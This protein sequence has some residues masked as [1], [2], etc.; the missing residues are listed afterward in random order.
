MR[1][2]ITATRR[3]PVSF[4]ELK[5]QDLIATS[6]D[7][8]VRTGEISNAYLFSGPQG[9]GKTTAARLLAAALQGTSSEQGTPSGK[10][11]QA[12]VTYAPWVNGGVAVDVIEIDGASHSGVHDV[13]AIRDQVLYP[14]IEYPYK[15]YIID[16]VHM[17]S[18]SAF[19][20]LLKTIEEPPS[21]IVFIFATTELQRMPVTI[22]SRCQQFHFQTIESPVIV[23]SL[24]EAGKEDSLTIE[25]MAAELMA[26]EAHGSLRDAYML[27][28]QIKTIAPKGK[29]SEKLALEHLGYHG[30]PT[31][32]KLVL[33]I[34]NAEEKE[35]QNC[36]KTLFANGNSVQT[37]LSFLMRMFRTAYCY[38]LDI[39]EDTL[40]FFGLTPES[41]QRY[42][43]MQC[44][45][46]VFRCIEVLR[47][48]QRSDF[49][50]VEAELLISD[51]CRLSSYRSLTELVA[52]LQT[53]A[54]GDAV[55]N[56]SSN[57]F[58]IPSKG[59]DYEERTT[60][61]I[62]IS[63]D[64]S[65][66]T[67]NNVSWKSQQKQEMT[68]L[69]D[70]A[71][72]DKAL[73]NYSVAKTDVQEEKKTR[74]AKTSSKLEAERSGDSKQNPLQWFKEVIA[75]SQDKK[76]LID[77]LSMIKRAW[78]EGKI[79]H[80]EV[81][82]QGVNHVISEN[83]QHTLGVLRSFDSIENIICHIKLRK[84][85]HNPTLSEMQP[86]LQGKISSNHE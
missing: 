65:E 24:Q 51:M 82:D 70:T 48:V 25:P 55:V 67:E 79:M 58:S 81:P 45:H 43:T 39:E 26:R 62:N 49:A 29:I 83:K 6:L 78:I 4:E 5:G 80:I 75:H 3:R 19:N 14:P 71:S 66:S 11:K 86:I 61:G 56:A 33:H 28:D 47:D 60:E 72:K 21:Y 46:G 85:G 32:R 22:R 2:H 69:E 18:N 54:S 31:F 44:E 53:L 17:L 12:S 34:L 7:K 20:A 42:S 76:Y 63:V 40:S 52:D 36:L 74:K 30:M 64:I 68:G 10:K 41:I 77:S 73:D 15:I 8:A 13:R 57:D 37:I 50:Q 59:L 23:S 9:V 16:E 38:T 35:A 1:R 27:Y 84:D